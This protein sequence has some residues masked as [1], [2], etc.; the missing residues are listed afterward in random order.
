MTCL[1]GLLAQWST[2]SSYHGEENSGPVWE[3]VPCFERERKLSTNY[4]M[5]ERKIDV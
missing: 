5:W 3:N 1:I 2:F 4:T